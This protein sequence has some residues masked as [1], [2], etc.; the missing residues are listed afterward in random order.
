MREWPGS[1]C[2]RLPIVSGFV[3]HAPPRRRDCSEHEEF[4]LPLEKPGESAVIGD[5]SW[6]RQF[7]TL[8]IVVGVNDGASGYVSFCS[9]FFSLVGSFCC[10]KRENNRTAPNC[11]PSGPRNSFQPLP[12]MLL[13]RRFMLGLRQAGLLP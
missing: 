3:H 11:N 2:P 5:R 7:P 6:F 9:F 13:H 4:P 1:L 10:H 12:R 8:A